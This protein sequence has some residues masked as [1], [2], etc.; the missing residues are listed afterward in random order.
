MQGGPI[1][2]YSRT[3]SASN[4]SQA[5]LPEI[6]PK[7][8]YQDGQNGPDGGLVAA[9]YNGAPDYPYT[10]FD[11][12]QF[13]PPYPP[14][15]QPPR[16]RQ[17]Y[18]ARYGLID[19]SRVTPGEYDLAYP[20]PGQRLS[21]HFPNT[22]NSL[23]NVNGLTRSN[24]QQPTDVWPDSQGQNGQI[25]FPFG[26]ALQNRVNQFQQSGDQT[27]PSNLT[28]GPLDT[29]Q[30]L[31]RQSDPQQATTQCSQLEGDGWILV[32]SENKPWNLSAQSVLERSMQNGW[33][34]NN[35]RNPTIN[36]ESPHLQS[37]TFLL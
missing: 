25:H 11:P 29:A 33:L 19:K 20:I 22:A 26:T 16:Q 32:D 35:G 9:A 18:D 10:A 12:A 8:L 7:P 1:P 27:M 37:L 3:L 4:S 14:G 31:Q 24:N 2:H 13:T 15:E 6:R 34:V 21:P 17:L 30:Y 5:P 23:E 28:N 36:G